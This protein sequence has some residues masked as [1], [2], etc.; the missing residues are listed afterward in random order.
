MRYVLLL[1]TYLPL[2]Q[3]CA[4]PNIPT[5]LTVTRSSTIQKERIVNFHCKNG[6]AEAQQFYVIRQLPLL[7]NE[8]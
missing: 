8:Y 1:M 3:Y 6:Y 4:T 7:F 5:L 2:K